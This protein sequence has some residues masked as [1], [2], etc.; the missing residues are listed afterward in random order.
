M[1]HAIR[2]AEPGGPE[3]LS[4][5]PVTVGDPGPGEVRLRMTAVGVNFI[6]IYHRTGLY[7]LPDRP[8]GLGLE[9]AGVIDA[10]GAGVTDLAVGDRVAFAGGPPGAYAEARLMPAD[11]LVS[12]P[13]WL[14]DTQ[15]AALMLQGMTARYLLRQTHELRAGD[16]ILVHAAAGGVGLLVCQWARALGA[17]V[18]GTVG[19]PDKATLAADHGCHHPI[20]YTTQDFVAEVRRLTNGRGVDVVYDGVG[21]ATFAGS[22]DCVRP[23]GLVV[24]F[25]QASGAIPPVELG[26][27]AAKGSLFLTRP[28]LFTYIATRVDLLANAT[29]LFAIVASGAVKTA[30]RHTFPLKD[31]A[32]A[33]RALESRQTTGAIVLIP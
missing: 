1:P 5:Q 29:E 16:T 2:L 28:T 3:V 11:R 9:G 32:Q 13:S 27:L 22:L 4:W 20:V 25:G 21:Q 26:V 12:L 6:D 14:S 30:D 33:H 24:S 10:L 15:A 17:I 7:P 31:A 23:R 19:T 8:Y 18:I